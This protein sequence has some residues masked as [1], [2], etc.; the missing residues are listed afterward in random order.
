[1]PLHHHVQHALV[2]VG[3]LVL[4]ELAETQAGLQ[5]HI[6]D[7][8]LELAAEHFHQRGFAGAVRADEAVTIAVRE[9]DGDVL[10]ERLGTKRIATFEVD[11]I[12]EFSN[13]K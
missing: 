12:L 11:S 13:Q 8:L 2:F 1:V 5:H 9:F 7:A 6:A 10:E 3:E 4:V